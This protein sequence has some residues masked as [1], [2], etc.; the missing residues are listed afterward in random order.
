TIA[1]SRPADEAALLA[2]K[3]VGPAFVERHSAS[4]FDVLQQAA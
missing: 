1:V 2:V 4:L 3:G